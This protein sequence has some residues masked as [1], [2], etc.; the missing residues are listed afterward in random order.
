MSTGNA[1]FCCC[2]YESTHYI[3]FF[4]NWLWNTVICCFARAGG[5]LLL[6]WNL[7]KKIPGM[8]R[9]ILR[10]SLTRPALS[11]IMTMC[12]VSRFLI[13]VPFIFFAFLYRTLDFTHNLNKN[14]HN[15]SYPMVLIRYPYCV[16]KP[17]TC[18]III[19]PPYIR[20]KIFHL[21]QL[22]ISIFTEICF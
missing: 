12:R 13:H 4:A 16:F 15:L 19:S 21:F 1:T 18:G 20:S 6:W 5:V 2:M 10:C 3:Q 7:L 11:V 17:Y 8:R 22:F 14:L 9:I